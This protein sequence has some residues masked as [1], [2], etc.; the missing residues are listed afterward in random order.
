[1]LLELNEE[2]IIAELGF[3]ETGGIAAKMFVDQPD[4]AVV[5]VAGS[6]GIVAEGQH[7]GEVGHGLER[8]LVIHWV[9]VVPG[10]GSDGGDIHRC[11]RIHRGCGVRLA[12]FLPTPYVGVAAVA[13]MDGIRFVM[14][15]VNSAF[16]AP[17]WGPW[18]HISLFDNVHDQAAIQTGSL[19][20]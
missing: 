16:H 4:L 3:G 10:S 11:R 2:E 14:E 8:M 13:G 17:Q 7:L 18:G 15:T 6:I 1:M 12:D 9:L 20:G 19:Y 5:R